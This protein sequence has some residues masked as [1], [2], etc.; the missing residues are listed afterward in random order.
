[1]AQARTLRPRL[2]PQAHRA[3]RRSWARS[4]RGAPVVRP[5]RPPRPL[6]GCRP[7]ASRRAKAQKN[8]HRT[9]LL[10]LRVPLAGAAQQARLLAAGRTAAAPP[11]L[12]SWR[13]ALGAGTAARRGK[14]RMRGAERRP[15]ARRTK[16]AMERRPAAPPRRPS[17]SPVR[18]L[19]R[20]TPGTVP[21]S[22]RLQF[23]CAG[24]F[25]RVR[26]DV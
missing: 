14:K 23:I 17:W 24:I 26:A 8:L 6:R 13:T 7:G 11:R 20:S 19:G 21:A 9:L 5:R 18:H 1:M 12:G 16:K 25:M 2:Q 10:P 15:A 22:R 4:A 3:A